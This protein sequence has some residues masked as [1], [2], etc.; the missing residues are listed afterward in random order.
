MLPREFEADAGIFNPDAVGAT[1]KA[2]VY[3]RLLA[4]RRPTVVG[5][6][7][8]PCPKTKADSLNPYAG[9]RCIQ[10]DRIDAVRRPFVK[11]RLHGV[12]TDA[13]RNTESQIPALVRGLRQIKLVTTMPREGFERFNLKTSTPSQ[14][15]LELG[16]IR[17]A[18]SEGA[19]QTDFMA[20]RA[21]QGVDGFIRRHRDPLRAIGKCVWWPRTRATAANSA[22]QMQ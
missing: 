10:F 17:S 1:A 9:I 7:L 18:A 5:Y 12:P 20:A 19:D 22:P 4:V 6:P 8:E 13:H 21:S 3:E 2:S 14:G 11:K 15:R 16:L